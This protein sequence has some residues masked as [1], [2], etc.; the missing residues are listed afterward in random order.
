M[1]NTPPI[2]GFSSNSPD[3]NELNS[4]GVRASDR[5]LPE[6]ALLVG[7]LHLSAEININIRHTPDSVITQALINIQKLILLVLSLI[8]FYCIMN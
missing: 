1:T 5:I 3:D 4:S 7:Y 8:Y 2:F 6:S